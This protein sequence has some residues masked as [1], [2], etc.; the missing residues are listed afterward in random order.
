[1]YAIVE[2]SSHPMPMAQLVTVAIRLM[3]PLNA[4]LYREFTTKRAGQERVR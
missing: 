2:S 1:M 4:I 3:T